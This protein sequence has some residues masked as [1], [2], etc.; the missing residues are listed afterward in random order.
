MKKATVIILA[1]LL[2]GGLGY[3]HDVR[4]EEESRDYDGMG[5][6]QGDFLFTVIREA[7]AKKVFSGNV[8]ALEAAEK[9][10]EIDPA[11]QLAHWMLARAQWY[12]HE[13][14]RRDVPEREVPT[15]DEPPG[16]PT[17]SHLKSLLSVPLSAK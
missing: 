2:T 11:S 12:R 14:W 7:K 5:L 15:P 16:P 8:T 17:Q 3:V 13:L 4:A 6:T 1:V 9:A 10:V